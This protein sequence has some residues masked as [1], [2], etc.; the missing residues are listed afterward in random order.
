MSRLRRRPRAA[1]SHHPHHGLE[2][3]EPLEEQRKLAGMGDATCGP[4]DLHAIFESMREF[5]DG[6]VLE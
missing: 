1:V 5:R 4:R 6:A 2:T 3:L